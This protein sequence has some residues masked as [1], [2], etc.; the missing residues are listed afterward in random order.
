MNEQDE[1]MTTEPQVKRRSFLAAI[2]AFVAL[3][4]GLRSQEHNPPETGRSMHALVYWD[5]RQG[6]IVSPSHGEP[7]PFAV[8][9]RADKYDGNGRLAI[10]QIELVRVKP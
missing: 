10:V 9:G 6:K 2:G 7:S 8:G 4:F 3:P 1:L 5:D